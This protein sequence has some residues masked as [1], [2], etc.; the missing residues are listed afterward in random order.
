ME[1]LI[2]REDDDLASTEEVS[3]GA[4]VIQHFDAGAQQ[5]ALRHSERLVGAIVSIG[6][7]GDSYDKALAETVVGLYKTE[8]V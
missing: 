7:V 4:G 5:T 8:C 1:G 2:L 6:T 3:A